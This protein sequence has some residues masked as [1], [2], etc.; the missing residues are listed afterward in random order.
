MFPDFED[1]GGVLIDVF[2]QLGAVTD[3]FGIDIQDLCH[4]GRENGQGNE[5]HEEFGADAHDGSGSLKS[6]RGWKSMEL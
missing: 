5:A 2:H 1:I 3:P 6:D 4:H